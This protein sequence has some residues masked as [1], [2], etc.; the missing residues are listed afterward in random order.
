MFGLENRYFHASELGMAVN[1][2]LVD[3]TF[4]NIMDLKFT[5]GMESD[6]DHVENGESDWVK[7][8]DDFYKPFV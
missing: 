4:N 6:L 7:V 2:I 1:D 5:A 3:R 8:V